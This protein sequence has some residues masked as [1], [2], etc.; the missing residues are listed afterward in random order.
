MKESPISLNRLTAICLSAVCLSAQPLNRCVAQEIRIL[1]DYIKSKD[2]AIEVPDGGFTVTRDEGRVEI[3]EEGTIGLE[4]GL[5]IRSNDGRHLYWHG[6][7]YR[8]R[9]EIRKIG[10]GR[11]G[12]VNTLELEDYLYGVLASEM[13]TKTW[14]LEALKAQAVVSRSYARHALPAT[15]N[16]PYQMG[17]DTKHQVYFGAAFEDKAARGAVDATRGEILKDA[18]GGI[19]PGYFH[20]CC[21]GRTEDAR[22]VWS[23]LAS[24]DSLGVSDFGSCQTSPHYA[25]VTS[26]PVEDLGKALVKLGYD[27]E[28]PIKSLL[29]GRLTKS[30]RVASLKVIAQNNRAEVPTDKLRQVLGP[31]WIRS[32]KITRIARQ[33][34]R[35][36]IYG[37]GWGHGVGLCQWGAKNMAERGWDY[38]KILRHYFPKARLAKN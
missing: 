31:N 32:T 4:D 33:D 35:F 24:K 17:A 11:L 12:L 18:R 7:P 27:F 14:P 3:D 20:S 10:D 26:I 15:A 1:L 16:A 38:E 21:G 9:L 5:I 37:K 23:R 29:I 28:P 8:G 2:L 6:K 36:V 25:W 30:M 13:D 22:F 19:L 34:K